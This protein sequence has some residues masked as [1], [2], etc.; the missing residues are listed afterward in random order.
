LF[1][2]WSLFF[3]YLLTSNRLLT[4]SCLMFRSCLFSIQPSVVL[5]L[6]IFLRLSVV[7]RLSVILQ[8]LCT[9][10]SSCLFTSVG[11]IPC[12][13]VDLPSPCFLL[14]SFSIG[15]TFYWTVPSDLLLSSN[16]LWYWSVVIMSKITSTYKIYLEY[17]CITEALCTVPL[18]PAS[19]VVMNLY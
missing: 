3:S 8:L 5:H 14:L 10:S 1:S 13:Y 12:L 4:S 16:V 11:G 18:G 2:T 6:V 15:L 19:Q 7:L 9:L 17:P